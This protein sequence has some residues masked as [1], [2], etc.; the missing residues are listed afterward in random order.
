MESC[1]VPYRY[2]TFRTVQLQQFLLKMGSL[3]IC[4]VVVLCLVTHVI[5]TS[6]IEHFIVLM[7]ENRSFDHMLG[8]LK[9]LHPSLNGIHFFQPTS[10]LR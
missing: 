1:I 6:K 2:R 4:L 9:S 10:R 8:F 3:F 7:L 5:A